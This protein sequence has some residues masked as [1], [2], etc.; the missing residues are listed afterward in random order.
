[1]PKASGNSRAKKTAKK[2]AVKK[3]NSSAKKKAVK[4]ATAN[5]STKSSK[6]KTSKTAKPKKKS[7]AKKTAK[8]GSVKKKTTKTTA[9]KV[10]I[11]SRLNK[12]SDPSPDTKNVAIEQLFKKSEPTKEKSAATNDKPSIIRLPSHV[13]LRSIEKSKF[14]RSLTSAE[15]IKIARVVSF[16]LAGIF[17]LFGGM[18]S[19]AHTSAL[20]DTLAQPAQ[21]IGSTDTDTNDNTQIQVLE[22]EFALLSNIPAVIENAH[23][24]TFTLTHAELRN[25][26]AENTETGDRFAFQAENTTADTYSVMVD[27]ASFAPGSYLMSVETYSTTLQRADVFRLS[28]FTIPAPSTAIAA[29]DDE[30]VAEVD[31]ANDSTDSLDDESDIDSVA[32]NANAPVTTDTAPTSEVEVTETELVPAQNIPSPFRF[33]LSSTTFSK[34]TVV[35]TTVPADLTSLEIYLT[36]FNS[37]TE[38]FLARGEYVFNSW[39]FYFN[40][41]NIP[42]GRYNLIAIGEREGVTL[43]GVPVT[44]VV[45]KELETPVVTTSAQ[46]SETETTTLDDETSTENEESATTT[47]TSSPATRSF[48]EL[49]LTGDPN[50]AQ[51]EASQIVTELLR[52]RKG[53]LELLLRNYSVA[54]Q[55]NDPTAVAL[56]TDALRQEEASIIE[57]SERGGQN[58]ARELSSRLASLREQIDTF[59]SLQR[60]SADPSASVD[61]DGDGITDLDERVLFRTDPESVDTDGDGII[62]AVEIMRGFDPNNP[63]A[64]VV[65]VHESP[66]ET[67]GLERPDTLKIE[68]VTPRV[69]TTP[70]TSERVVQSVITGIALPNSYVTLYIY[71]TPTIVTVRADETGRFT[72]TFERELIDGEHEVYVA[73]TDNNGAIVAQSEPFRF[74]KEAEAFTVGSAVVE[75]TPVAQTDFAPYSLTLGIGVIALGIVLLMLG[76]GLRPE[77]M[78]QAE[79]TT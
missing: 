43:R 45:S 68:S 18:Y 1:M 66:R 76:F 40:T 46:P 2:A 58:V 27:S 35:L 63:V 65:I 77:P 9:R 25:V 16:S 69:I 73:L 54:V 10:A 28:S 22:P 60:E 72:Y 74:V 33:A 75:S 44:V 56:A 4:K 37:P 79:S 67:V 39:R 12:K 24:V 26:F 41:E 7:V 62:D 29:V 20:P 3:T 30:L 31:T 61:T 48:T 21:L 51:S 32:A 49:S 78:L 34:P 23:R 15:S 59:E 6:A 5:Q 47:T 19:L 38:R 14:I 17:I 8:K 64:E 11:K 57:S 55:G 50:T 52:A 42:N 13:S 71:S 53:N 70:D 36:P